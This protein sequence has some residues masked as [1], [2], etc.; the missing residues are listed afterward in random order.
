[1]ATPPVNVLTYHYDTA[2]SGVNSNEILL[3]PANVNVASFGKQFTVSVDGAV[4]AQ[5]LIYTGVTITA[6]VNTNAGAAGVHDVV[7]VATEHDSLYAID[8]NTGTLLWKRTFLDTTNP[9]SN[10]NNTFNATEIVPVPSYDVG[11]GQISPEIGITGTPVI[12]QGSNLLY[13]SPRR[14]KQSMRLHA[15]N[16]A[17]GTDAANPFLIGDTTSS[18][19]SNFLSLC[20]LW[21]NPRGKETNNTR[22][23]VYGCGDGSVLDPT[24]TGNRIV[25]FNA[26]RQHQRCALS[27]VS[28]NVYVQWAS[29]GDNGPYHGWVVVW[30]VAD[31]KGSTGFQLKGVLNT[32]PN[33]GL[34]GIWESGGRLVFE[35]DG[36]AFYFASGNGTG[37]VPTLDSNGFPTNANYENSLVK[38][39]ADST[40]NALNQ[41][42]NGWGL[43]VADYFMPY[44]FA[45]LDLSDLDFGAGGPLLLPDSAGN[46]SHPHLMIAGGKEGKIYLISRDNL[47]GFN[48]TDDNVLNAI[49]NSSGHRT[50]P[51]QIGAALSTAAFFNNTIY[52]VS[53]QSDRANAY[54]INSAKTALIMTSQTAINDFGDYPGSVIVSANG[55]TAGIVWVMDRRANQIHAYDATN[56]ATELWNS[57]QMSGDDLGSVVKFAVPTVANGKVYVGTNNSLVVYGLTI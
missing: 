19:R 44:N 29:H 6:G 35:P 2:S 20:C 49:L 21:C 13:V 14:K 8:A 3:T 1:M 52:W 18:S 30:N 50:P 37:A 16:I 32:S 36:S 53:G 17:D 33:N 43:K 48:P 10:V 46:M 27:L 40:T 39:V 47:G 11:S 41:N 5:P 4:Y 12:D 7:F 51:V 31:V 57:G 34:A 45:S 9:G 54:V 24:G 23:Y 42:F 15:I 38:V 25:Q 28:N 55:S 22:I 56:F 26:L